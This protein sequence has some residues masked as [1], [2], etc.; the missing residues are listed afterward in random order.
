MPLKITNSP[1]LW[2]SPPS[3]LK[4]PLPTANPVTVWGAPPRTIE[5][6]THVTPTALQAGMVHTPISPDQVIIIQGNTTISPTI[7]LLILPQKI[8]EARVALENIER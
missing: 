2:L 7:H 6:M 8:Q 4:N 5:V 1:T 3:I